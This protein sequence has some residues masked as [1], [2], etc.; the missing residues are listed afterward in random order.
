MKVATAAPDAVTS[1]LEAIP[2]TNINP[3][4]WHIVIQVALVLQV[5]YTR[6][7][8]RLV[9]RALNSTVS[10]AVFR[11]DTLPLVKHV[12]DQKMPEA[13]QL[14]D[15]VMAIAATD[16]RRTRRSWLR[17]VEDF[18]LDEIF[19]SIIPG[20]AE[21][22]RDHTLDL[23]L[24]KLRATTRIADQ[25]FG[26][27]PGATRSWCAHIDRSDGH[28]EFPARLTR[29][30]Y[31]QARDSVN[32]EASA[33]RVCG[34]L[35]VESHEI[36]NRILIRLLAD[37]GQLTPT[38]LDWLLVSDVV[39]DPPFGVSEVALAL[40]MHF[41]SASHDAR[42]LFVYALERGP[43][44]DDIAWIMRHRQTN[45]KAN[46]VIDISARVTEWQRRRIQWFQDRLPEDLKALAER[47]GVE[48][49][50]LSTR[51]QALA[52]DGFY[53]SSFGIGPSWRDTSPKTIEELRAMPPQQVLSYMKDW[54]PPSEPSYPFES[55]MQ[56]IDG[57]ASVISELVVADSAAMEYLGLVRQLLTF[58]FSEQRDGSCSSSRR[59]SDAAR[60]VPSP[61][62]HR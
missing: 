33:A 34:V 26:N 3:T 48:P 36:F 42:R 6:R 32:D 31:E 60:G 47:L 2:P 55:E 44:L 22:D 61:A 58:V 27:N 45:E 19:N 15:T 29:S 50:A 39:L 18:R 5:P 13:F 62:A 30:V 16:E 49:T 54:V 51:E 25:Q 56:S 7:S 11:S 1:I 14:V 35:A 46:D 9:R 52:E 40:R 4:V 17:H 23:L 41:S 38:H 10:L 8:V 20:L 12:I 43:G 24:K 28:D 59:E 37:V 57:F 21:I 53:A